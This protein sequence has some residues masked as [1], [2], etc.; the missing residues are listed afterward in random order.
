MRAAIVTRF[1]GRDVIEA[2]EDPDPIIPAPGEIS[3]DVRHAPVGLVD[4]F[5]RPGV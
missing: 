5:I 3:L 1:G 2:S 4:V